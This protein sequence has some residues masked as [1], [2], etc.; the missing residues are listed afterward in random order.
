MFEIEQILIYQLKHSILRTGSINTIT[1]IDK[2]HKLLCGSNMITVSQ[3]KHRNMVE[4][5]LISS[6]TYYNSVYTFIMVGNWN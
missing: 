6:Q 3:L 5:R 2:S 4:N 1:T